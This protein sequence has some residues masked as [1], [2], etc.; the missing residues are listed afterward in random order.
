LSNNPLNIGPSG[1]GSSWY[2]INGPTQ[3]PPFYFAD[4]TILGPK[5]IQ[6]AAGEKLDLRYRF[7]LSRAAWTADTLKAALAAWPAEKPTAVSAAAA[8]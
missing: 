2:L 4:Q 1:S 6:L 5:P 7:V 3:R 8:H